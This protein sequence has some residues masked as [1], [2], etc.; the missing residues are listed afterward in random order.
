VSAKG[1]NSLL[2]E[3][4]EGRGPFSG[5]FRRAGEWPEIVREKK[6]NRFWEI[7]FTSAIWGGIGAGWQWPGKKNGAFFVVGA[8]KEGLGAPAGKG[9]GATVGE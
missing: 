9:K 6:A 4:C 1:D 2:G 3:P 7:I 8:G 5:Y